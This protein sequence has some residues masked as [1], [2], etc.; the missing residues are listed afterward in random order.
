MPLKKDLIVIPFADKAQIGGL[1]KYIDVD[2]GVRE[3]PVNMDYTD[4]GYLSRNPGVTTFANVGASGMVRRLIKYKKK[5]NTTYKLRLE[6]QKLLKYDA[7]TNTYV[8]LQTESAALTGTVSIP[9]PTAGTGTLTTNATAVVGVGTNFTGELTANVSYIVVGGVSRLVTAIA[10]NTHATIDVAF[11]VDI[12]A[13][14]S[15]TISSQIVTGVGTAFNTDLVVGQV[16]RLGTTETFVVRSITDATH[17]VVEKAPTIAVV[18]GAYYKDSEYLFD[19]TAKMGYAEYLDTLYF[20]N[21]VD[22]FATFDGT[23]LKFV[24]ALPRGNIYNVYKDR[25]FI[26]GTIREPLTTYYSDPAAPTTFGGSS[27]FQLVGTDKVTGLITYYSSLII[28]KEKS[29]HKMTFNYDP[30]AVAFLPE[31]DVVNT[32][33]GCSSIQGYTWVENNVWFFTGT[34]VRAVGFKDQQIGVLGVDNSILSNQIKETLKTITTGK[35]DDVVVFY[36]NRKFHLSIAIGGATYN[37]SIFVCYTLYSN[38]WAK[39][40]NRIKSS[41]SDFMVDNDIIYTASGDVTGV[42][43]QWTANY[44]DND[45]D[46]EYYVTFQKYVDKDFAAR[47]IWRYLDLQFKNLEAAAQIYIYTDDFDVRNTTTA[48]F[49]IGT[50]LENEENA[51]GEVD[52]GEQLIADAFGES[53]EAVTFINRRISF[54]KKSQT[55]QIRVGGL[56]KN[57]SFTLAQMILQ[58]QSLPRRQ[59]SPASIISIN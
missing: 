53:V 51:L 21:G 2:D 41:V 56:T 46:Y 12:P 11:D 17:F 9:L 3:V 59:Y 34:E 7:G 42:M 22:F 54:I 33:Y 15:F 57:Q 24:R 40:V 38:K 44:N 45:A 58:G 6:G 30:I 25:I 32:N 20:G 14:T 49:Y 55:I 50:Q 16:V 10:D 52:I 48:P 47:K 26:S 36:A 5:N 13:G 35:E 31:F 23:Q 1:T 27:V 28:F 19:A 8:T 18:A 4:E 37:N 43:Y 39:Y 29:V